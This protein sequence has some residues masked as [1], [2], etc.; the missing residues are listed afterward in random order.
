MVKPTVMPF[1]LFC[2]QVLKLELTHGQRV[3]CKVAFGDYNP[4]DLVWRS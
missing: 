1:Y 2:E 3:V 4:E